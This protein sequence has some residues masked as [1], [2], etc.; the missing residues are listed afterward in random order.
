MHWCLN[1][2]CGAAPGGAVLIRALAPT[3]GVE[4]MQA[5]RGRHD[6]R[7]LCAGPGRLCQALDVSRAHDGLALTAPPFSLTLPEAPVEID[8]GVRIGIGKAIEQPWRFG[9]AGS[10]FVSRSFVSRRRSRPGA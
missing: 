6:L 3:C 2:V 5:R 10:P 9:L 8:V 7:T 1:A 4:A